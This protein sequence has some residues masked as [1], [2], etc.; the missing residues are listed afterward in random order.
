MP[1]SRHWFILGRR[2]RSYSEPLTPA[3]Q[4]IDI[5]SLSPFGKTK[6]LEGFLYSGAF[7]TSSKQIE[8]LLF[9]LKTVQ[10][11]SLEAF[12]RETQ[13]ILPQVR[14]HPLCGWL[15]E[16][17]RPKGG[18]VNLLPRFAPPQGHRLP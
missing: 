15:D 16:W 11:V 5:D 6:L 17:G 4:Q 1:I 3:L 12:S 8:A 18:R 2:F 10:S 13:A 7:E 9:D 14:H